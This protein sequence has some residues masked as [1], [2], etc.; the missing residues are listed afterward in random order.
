M[1]PNFRL[2][3]MMVA[4]PGWIKS[5]T[6]KQLLDGPYSLFAG[7]KLDPH[8][9]ATMTEAGYVGTLRLGKEGE[10]VQVIGAAEEHKYSIIGCEEF[11]ALAA[12]MLT[13]HSKSLDV[14]M[15]TGLESGWVR[16]RLAAGKI[17]YQTFH[18][19]WAGT[20][21]M[22]FDP[23]AGMTR[24]FIFLVKTPTQR[25]KRIIKDARIKGRYQRFSGDPVKHLRKLTDQL[26]TKIG[27]LDAIH[28]EN[29][30][31]KFIRSFQVPHYEDQLYE[32]LALGYTI[33]SKPF[34]KELYVTLDENLKNLITHAHQ[35][36]NKLKR[37]LMSSQVITILRDHG[38]SMEVNK[39]RME[40]TNISLSWMESTRLINMLIR[41]GD[42]KRDGIKVILK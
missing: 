27:N 3:I 41:S 11:S 23:T 6:L 15:L 28:F 34:E 5:F 42:C 35:W 30:L 18:T 22:R 26:F 37:G 20:Q 36:R 33:M 17:E 40:L 2:H 8:F 7:T 13:S 24:R 31:D 12:M 25:D 19:L 14:A 10:K 9:E 32:R 39:L 29:R 1:V 16:K 21:P 38:G 4:P